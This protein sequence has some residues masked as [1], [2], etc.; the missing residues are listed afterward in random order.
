MLVTQ[1]EANSRWCPFGRQP[2]Y[3][4]YPISTGLGGG[5]AT[6]AM[7]AVNRQ[8]SGDVPSCLGSVCMAWRWEKEKSLRELDMVS[9]EVMDEEPRRGYCG[10]FGKPEQGD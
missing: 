8:P 7:T 6:I 9:G 4:T 5:S 10:A 2:H 3:M 1:K